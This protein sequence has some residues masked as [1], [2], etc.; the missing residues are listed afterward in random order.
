MRPVAHKPAAA[1]AEVLLRLWRTLQR[2]ALKRAP[3]ALLLAAVFAQAAVVDRVAV[4][5]DNRVVKVSDI[6]RELRVTA[7][8]NRQP[9]D[10][11]SAAMHKA[12]ER[13][14]DQALVRQDL[15]NS[16]Y[17]QPT[18]KDAAQFLEQLKRDRFRGSEQQFQAELARHHLTEDQLRRQLLWQLTVLRFIDQRFRPGVLVTDEEVAAWRQQHPT[19][20]RTTTTDQIREALAGDRINQAFDEW[21]AETRRNTRIEF[22]PQAFI[23]NT[24]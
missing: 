15:L 8:L 17:S 6:Q 13:L 11:G 1:S 4:V 9:L 12:A 18:E 24:Q 10:E 3:Q 21:L 7:F 5:V 20:S 16:Q 22:R 23:G 14:I 19:E 2:A